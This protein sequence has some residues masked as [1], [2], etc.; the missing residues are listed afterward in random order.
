MIRRV[1]ELVRA[2]SQFVIATHS[3][4]L[5]AY[6]DAWIHQISSHGIRRVL[7]EDTEHYIVAKRFLNDPYQQLTTLLK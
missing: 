7:L 2:Q 1:H 4:M 6:P 3:P 5:M